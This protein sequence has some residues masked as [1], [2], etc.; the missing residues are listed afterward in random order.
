MRSGFLTPLGYFKIQACL[1]LNVLAMKS[2]FSLPLCTHRKPSQKPATYSMCVSVGLKQIFCH[3]CKLL[4]QA[5]LWKNSFWYYI[6]KYVI[7]LWVN[8]RF[9]TTAIIQILLT[10]DF[11]LLLTKQNCFSITERNHNW[12]QSDIYM[13]WWNKTRIAKLN[14]VTL[15]CY[16]WGD[17]GRRIRFEYIRDTQ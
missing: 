17:K 16:G 5:Q 10:L 2:H 4:Q 11:C 8:Y 3:H 7:A 6:D 12:I 14:P 15:C 9:N 13:K 1:I